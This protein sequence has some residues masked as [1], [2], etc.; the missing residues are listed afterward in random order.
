MTFKLITHDNRHSYGVSLTSYDESG[1]LVRGFALNTFASE[2]E[3]APY[4]R[5]LAHITGFEVEDLRS[6]ARLPRTFF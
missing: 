5:E 2:S 1:K 3:R 4:L 6:H